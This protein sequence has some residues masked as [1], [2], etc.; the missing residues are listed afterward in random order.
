MVQLQMPWCQW[1]MSI[2]SCMIDPFSHNDE[3]CIRWF[4][5][6][7]LSIFIHLTQ[8]WN[9]LCSPITQQYT[10]PWVGSITP[11]LY[12]LMIQLFQNSLRSKSNFHDPIR[13]HF[14]TCHDSWTVVTCA[15]LWPDST[16]IFCIRTRYIFTIFGLWAYKSHVKWVSGPG[17]YK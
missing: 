1:R 13:S 12:E 3:S 5:P 16:T 6:W 14:C 15:K 8:A 10:Q 9:S 2:C 4:S 11:L 17:A 7:L